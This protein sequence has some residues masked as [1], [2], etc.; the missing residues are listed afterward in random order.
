MRVVH[1]ITRLI[2][3]GAQENTVLTVEGLARFPGYDV[4][5]V[6]GPA[7]GPEGQ[8]MDRAARSGA[9][10]LVIPELRREIHPLR[11]LL[12]YVKILSV[13]RQL[14]P[15]VVHTHSSKAGI[16]ARLAA[17]QLNVPVIVHTI[18]GLPFHP[19][20]SWLAN[21][22]FVLLERMAARWSDKIVT[23]ADAMAEKAIAAGVGNPHL[24]QTIYSGMEVDTFLNTRG[25]R[26]QVRKEL[27]LGPRDIVIGKIAR[28]F[29][30]KGHADILQVAP[31]VV[32][33]FPDVRFLFVGDG[34]LK[35]DLKAMA[36]RLG[37]A[38][39]IVFAGLVPPERIPAMIRAMDVVVHMSLRE[40]L[41]RVL[42]Q[43]LISGV[44]VISYDIDGAK[45]VVREGETGYLVP[46]QSLPDL[47]DAILR[48]LKD[49][50]AARRMALRGQELFS[51]RFR[52]EHMVEKIAR[53]YDELLKKSAARSRGR[54]ESRA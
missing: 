36:A 44:P 43:A 14:N 38:D 25:M 6:T 50:P 8:L 15:H 32:C 37:V 41:A 40:G 54:G 51:E 9:R 17:Q 26:D 31:E 48:V 7:L 42:P 18:H 53:L 45:E 49:L 19:Y 35:D 3:G 2:L 27:G 4:T 34:I 11:D 13:L 10:F 28:L 33:R 29:E 52:A 5:L 23:V 30:L 20:Q 24:F 46:P 21:R 22:F 39:R 1:V 12:S 16:L 47:K